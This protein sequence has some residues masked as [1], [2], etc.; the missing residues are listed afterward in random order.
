[1]RIRRRYVVFEVVDG[2]LNIGQTLAW[3]YKELRA[4]QREIRTIIYEASFGKGILFCSHRLLD[5]LRKKIAE[6]GI[7]IKIIGV[8]GT[9][10]AAKRKFWGPQGENGAA[11]S[12]R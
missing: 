12:C 4:D 8:S 1:M 2:N 9:I 6:R 11:G 7:P 3:L 5:G 10:R